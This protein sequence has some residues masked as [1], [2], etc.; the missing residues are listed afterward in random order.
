MRRMTSKTSVQVEELT[1]S[2]PSASLWGSFKVKSVEGSR[3]EVM[4]WALGTSTDVERIEI[5]AGDA[6]VASTSPCLPRAEVAREFPD[7]QSAANCGFEVVMEARGKGRSTL[8][9]RA[10]LEDGSEVP[11]GELRVVAPGRAWSGVLRRS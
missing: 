1:S 10:V 3:L 5:V 6:V 7:R 8:G 9:L 11:I 2:L 4:G